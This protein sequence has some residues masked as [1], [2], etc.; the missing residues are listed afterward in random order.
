VKRTS[1]VHATRGMAMLW[2]SLRIHR[3]SSA[4]Q[5][6]LKSGH[7]TIRFPE[8]GHRCRIV[9]DFF[10]ASHSRLGRR[11][12]AMMHSPKAAARRRKAARPGMGEGGT[13]GSDRRHTGPAVCTE[14]AAPFE[15]QLA[16]ILQA[17][18]PAR[19]IE[20]SFSDLLKITASATAG[21]SPIFWR[22]ETRSR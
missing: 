14:T 10:S 2:C 17:C 1:R 20:Q 16:R 6:C 18:A 5:C 15:I 22:G 19:D 12:D 4:R 11:R 3:D 7:L 8:N 9:P 13:M 21:S